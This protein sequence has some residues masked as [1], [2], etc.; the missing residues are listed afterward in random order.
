[1]II[2]DI[3]YWTWVAAAVIYGI[4]VGIAFYYALK[5][6]MGLDVPPTPDWAFTDTWLKFIKSPY[7]SVRWLIKGRHDAGI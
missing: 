6:H 3:F 7:P 4:P 1:M 2:I 5:Q